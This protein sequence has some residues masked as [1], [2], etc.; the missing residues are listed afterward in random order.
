MKVL[1][2]GIRG[3]LGHDVMKELNKRGIGCVGVDLAEMDI[4]DRAS[5]DAV[6]DSER[7]DAVIHCAAWTAV[8]AAEDHEAEVRKVNVDGTKYLAEA[9]ARLGEKIMYFSTDYVFNGEGET[10]WKPYDE[11]GPMSVYGSSKLDGER[12]LKAALDRYFIVRLQWVYGINGKNFVKTMLRLAK[13]RDTL[14]V[15]NDQVG[16][17]TY[18]V[19]IAKLAVDMILT[20]KYGTY[21]AANTGYC[22]WYEFAQAIFKEAGMDIHVIPVSSDEYPAKARRPHNS[23]LDTSCLTDSG[24]DL[25]PPWEDA[26]KRYMS[27]LRESDEG[28]L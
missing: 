26:L 27:E 8:D 11:T 25:L 16:A 3:Q 17:P 4:T 9:A 20:D 21:H 10:P 19:D 12:A 15:V 22:S 6:L 7:P 5:V 13:T 18:T 14:T 28:L 23:R 1:V 24:F 2:T